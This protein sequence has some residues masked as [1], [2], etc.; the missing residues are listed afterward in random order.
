[1]IKM[2]AKIR[3]VTH[4]KWAPRIA[5]RTLQLKVAPEEWELSAGNDWTDL[6]ATHI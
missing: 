6:L 1:M 5:K 3:A 4:D 2:N